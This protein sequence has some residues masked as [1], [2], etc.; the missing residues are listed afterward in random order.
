MKQEE[1][2]QWK[3]VLEQLQSGLYLTS[4][5]ALRD[6][7]IISFPKRITELRNMGHKIEQERITTKGKWG[8]KSVNRYWMLPI[9]N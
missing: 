9:K 2:P 4:L 1:K 7:G 5:D 8:K 3:L 6:L